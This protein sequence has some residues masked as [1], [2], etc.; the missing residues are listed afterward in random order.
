M[1]STLLEEADPNLPSNSNFEGS[2][3]LAVGA[4]LATMMVLPL[5]L[6]LLHH[7]VLR[8][9]S[10]LNWL[11]LYATILVCKCCCHWGEVVEHGNGV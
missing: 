1:I 6:Q 4:M 2:Q 5:Q 10:G 11:S 9:R 8:S 3:G 7:V